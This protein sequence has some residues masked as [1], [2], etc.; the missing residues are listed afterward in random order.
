MNFY[1]CLLL[2]SFF[3]SSSC[4][5]LHMVC[6]LCGPATCFAFEEEI[7]VCNGAVMSSHGW[8]HVLSCA[9]ECNLSVDKN[10]DFSQCDWACSLP[11]TLNNSILCTGL[12]NSYLCDRWE[13]WG[14]GP[15]I[16]DSESILLQEVGWLFSTV[17]QCCAP[18]LQETKNIRS[19]MV[20]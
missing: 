14:F 2:N 20:E 1:S 4:I 3:Q 17:P 6:S 7:L 15:F 12:M 19:Y 18:P 16:R 5:H 10:T 8:S 13:N 9:T 11:V